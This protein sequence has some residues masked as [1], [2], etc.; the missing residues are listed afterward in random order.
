MGGG[1]GD[2]KQG[3][4]DQKEGGGRERFFEWLYN[5]PQGVQSNRLLPTTLVQKY[6][7]ETKLH[8]LGEGKGE[9]RHGSKPRRNP[10]PIG[11]DYLTKLQRETKTTTEEGER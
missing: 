3:D 10:G 2:Q 9:R 8:H 7:Y 6:P 4:D 11:D 5:G 1:R